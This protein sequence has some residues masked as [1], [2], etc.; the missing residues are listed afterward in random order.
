MG[1]ENATIVA[2]L[3]LV[4]GAKLVGDSISGLGA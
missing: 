1:R 4:I 2:F 3:C